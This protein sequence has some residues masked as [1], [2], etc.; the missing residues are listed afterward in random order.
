LIPARTSWLLHKRREKRKRLPGA[1]FHRASFALISARA[2]CAESVEVKWLSGQRQFLHDV[3][4][5]Q[6]YVIEESRNKKFKPRLPDHVFGKKA[7]V[8]WFPCWK[9]I[10]GL[11][12]HLHR[13]V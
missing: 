13:S 12:A 8:A 4:A 6:S 10:A 5:N 3:D 7:S 9:G 11:C 2:P 1:I